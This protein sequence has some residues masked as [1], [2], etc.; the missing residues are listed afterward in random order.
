MLRFNRLAFNITARA[1]EMASNQTIN[2]SCLSSRA[3]TK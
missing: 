3:T 1:G 2:K